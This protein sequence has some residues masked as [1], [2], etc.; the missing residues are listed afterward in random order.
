[1]IYSLAINKYK[2]C[3]E[4]IINAFNIIFEKEQIPTFQIKIPNTTIT[5]SKLLCSY[6]SEILL[7]EF[8]I[9]IDIDLKMLITLLFKDYVNKSIENYNIKKIFKEL[10]KD[11]LNHE[12]LTISNGTDNYIYEKS[13]ISSIEIQ[14]PSC[15]VNKGML[16]LNEIYE[17]YK[18]RI[19][20]AKMLENIWIGFIEDYKNNTSQKNT[21]LKYL[22]QLCYNYYDY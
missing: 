15:E 12:T 11:Y 19:S 2:Q 14:F 16:I 8:N 9:D 3:L 4:V 7:S 10:S 13:D 1:M 20:F 22:I 6:V 5:R 17:T 21:K 18:Y